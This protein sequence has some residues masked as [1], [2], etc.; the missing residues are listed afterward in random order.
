[1]KISCVSQGGHFFGVPALFLVGSSRI[2]W[3]VLLFALFVFLV[4]E[5]ALGG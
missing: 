2:R 1:M 5:E 4:S 3:A